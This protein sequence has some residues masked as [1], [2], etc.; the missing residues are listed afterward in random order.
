M[1]A[2][3]PKVDLASNPAAAAKLIEEVKILVDASHLELP[4][5]IS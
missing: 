3:L 2:Y 4:Q 1:R 5:P